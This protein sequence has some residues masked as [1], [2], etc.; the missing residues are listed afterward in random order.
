MPSIRVLAR[1]F[2]VTHAIAVV[3]LSWPD[4]GW[5]LLALV[6]WLF[7]AVGA[8]EPQPTRSIRHRD[9][10]EAERTRLGQKLMHREGW[11][12]ER[13][14]LALG[15]VAL[16]S[17]LTGTAVLALTTLDPTP[18]TIARVYV[19]TPALLLGAGFILSTMVNM[20]LVTGPI[21]ALW[22]VGLVAATL[23]GQWTILLRL[24]LVALAVF[25]A[26][27]ALDLLRGAR[28]GLERPRD[29][30]TTPAG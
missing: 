5:A 16:I 13:P 4:W 25:T 20:W 30:Q 26:L 14:A 8:D 6:C 7:A 18:L 3:A 15:L 29:P 10:Q 28:R 23:E 21:L 1:C 11:I 19:W 22:L 24:L 9:V 12:V 2:V 17:I 27:F